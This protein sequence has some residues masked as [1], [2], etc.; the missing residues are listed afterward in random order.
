MAEATQPKPNVIWTPWPGGQTK[1]ITC[2]IKE[3]FAEGNRGGG[4]RLADDQP[5]LTDRGWLMA[6]NVT[7]TDRLVAPDGT[8]TRIAGM[9]RGKQ[10]PYYRITTEGGAS[11]VVCGEHNWQ[12]YSGKNGSRD[13]WQVKTTDELRKLSGDYYLPLMSAPAPGEKWGGLDPYIAGY[14]LGDGTTNA[15]NVVIYTVDDHTVEY[16]Q[17]AGWRKY[18]YDSQSTI[19]MT[20]PKPEGRIWQSLLGRH[21]GKDKRVPESLL[22]SDPKTRLAVLRGLMDSDGSVETGNGTSVRPGGQ[23]SFVNTSKPLAEAVQYLVRSLGGKARVRWKD[24]HSERG[25]DTHG[26]WHVSITHAN[27][28]NPF[29]MPRKAGLVRKQKGDKDRIVSIEPVGLRDGVCF[30]VEHHSHLFVTKDFIVTHNTDTLIMKYLRYVGVGFGPAWTGIIFRREYKHLDDI[31]KK[32][33]RWIPQIFPGAKWKASKSDYKWV[34]PD[35]EELLFRRMKDPDDYWSYHGHEYPFIGWEELTNWPTDA[36]Y[37]VMRSCNRCSVADV[38]RFYVSSG[39]PFGAGHGWVKER[40]IDIGPEGTVVD[41]G[42]GNKRVRIHVDLEDNITMMEND[43]DYEKNLNGIQNEELKKAWRHGDWNITVGG[44]LQGIWETKRHV[45]KPFIPPVDWPRWRGMDWG[46]AKPYSIGW[47]TINP[48]G[49]VIRYREL[50]GYGGKA[51][52]GTK[53]SGTEVAKE[54]KKI[55]AREIRAGAKFRKNPADSNL[56]TNTGNEKTVG[57]LFKAQGVRWVKAQK[58][59]GSRVN[60]AALIIDALKHDK[61]QVTEN[62]KHWLRTVPVLMPNEN[63]WEDVDTE[64]EDHAWD[65]TMYSLRSRHKVIQPDHE[66]EGPKPGTFDWLLKVS[67]TSRTERVL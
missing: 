40:F 17:H 19:M 59:P 20:C 16:L 36:C 39:N 56:W 63:N 24:K 50:Y 4:K 65:E 2:P 14:I 45:I 44:F 42:Q 9:Y 22:M 53:E 58:G 52:T 18:N 62:C 32:S 35:G 8:Y 15:A 7:K 67:S 30:E 54:I 1:F 55:E 57:D 33:K 51:N 37:E 21:A 49:V 6:G 29:L 26:Y 66:E 31:V 41:D 60:G 64:M 12:T 47:Y 25:G 61:F 23:C 34:F 46:T 27:K 43:P 38:P 13:G 3:I 10:E 11:V 48:D 28:F 5:V